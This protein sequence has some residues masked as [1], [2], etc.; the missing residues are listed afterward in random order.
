MNS[1]VDLNTIFLQGMMGIGVIFPFIIFLTIIFSLVLTG[2]I[3]LFL[4]AMKRRTRIIISV[5]IFI[6]LPILFFVCWLLFWPDPS[7]MFN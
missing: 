4:P 5:L 1:T 3:N 2:V 6:L 7:P